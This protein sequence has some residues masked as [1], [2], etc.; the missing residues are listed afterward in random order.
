MDKNTEK[1]LRR[2]TVLRYT[3]QDKLRVTILS[4]WKEKVIEWNRQ[5]YTSWL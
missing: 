4:F 3:V 2:R 1:P 5:R